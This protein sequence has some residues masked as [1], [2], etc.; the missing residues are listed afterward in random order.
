MQAQEVTLAILEEKIPVLGIAMIAALIFG[1]FSKKVKIPKVTAYI[2][3]GILIGPTGLNLMSV[4]IADSFHFLADIAMGLILF[5]IGGDFDRDLIK[6]LGPKKFKEIAVVILL[7][8]VMVFTLTFFSYGLV[9]QDLRMTLIISSFLSFVA[10]MTAPPTTLLVMK[11]YNAKGPLQTSILTFLAMGTVFALVGTQ[12]VEVTLKILKIWPSADG[13]TPLVQMALLAWSLLGSV[14]LGF[15]LGFFLSYWEQ[16]EKKSSEFLMLVGSTILFGQTLSYYLNT[17]PLIISAVIGFTVVNSSNTGKEIH[18]GINDMGLSI[19]AIFFILAGAHINLREF[20]V[21]TF[22]MAFIYIIC[23]IVGFYMASRLTGK[24]VSSFNDKANYFGL[25]TLS[26]AGVALAVVS[27]IMP[28]DTESS[29]LIVTIILSSIFVFEIIG[30]LLLK[31]GLT[32]AKEIKEV[33]AG[34]KNLSKKTSVSMGQLIDNLQ[35]NL[36]I[37]KDQPKITNQGIKHLIKTD[38]ISVKETANITFVQKFVYQHS[39]PFYPVIDD[40]QKFL[41]IINLTELMEVS[42]EEENSFIIAKSLLC[43]FPTINHDSNLDEVI[44]KFSQ[45]KYQTLPVVH[46]TSK[47]LLGCINQKDI[48]KKV[49]EGGPKKIID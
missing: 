23:R 49:S 30:P 20:T 17:D 47:K 13:Q 31:W 33:Q 9:T 3:T 4:E 19:Y 37:K 42:K 26:H 7:T 22:T 48:I 46:S 8:F 2:F 6:I 5:N 12:V 40:E 34:D 38:M 25:S 41:G 27:K 39:S 11:E 43:E 10:L 24:L 28:I 1:Q 21:T 32:Q 44:E 16:K 18:Q 35:E 29:N 45:C 36:N 14:L 15:I